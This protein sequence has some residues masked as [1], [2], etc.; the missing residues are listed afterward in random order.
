M[1]EKLEGKCIIVSAP[2]GAG[3]TTIVK[4]LLR[5]MPKLSFSISACSREPRSTEVEGKDYYFVGVEGFKKLIAEKA[6]IEWE[7]VY[8]NN[9]YGTL[10]EELNRIWS[11]KQVVVFDVDVIG[12]LRLK[13]I[14]STQALSIFIQPPSIQE[15]ENRLR[16]RNSESEEKINIRVNK[17]K[18]ELSKAKEF[19]VTVVNEELTLAI[20]EAKEQVLKFIE[21]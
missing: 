3:K 13:E 2:S 20:S 16:S 15:L 1:K 11:N 8:E 17:A 10:K 18:I 4:A 21:K 12:G 9:F 5:D 7:E 19:D 6:F 14:F